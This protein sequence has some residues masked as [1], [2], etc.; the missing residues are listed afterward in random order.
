MISVQNEGQD[1]VVF[2]DLS[3]EYQIMLK[4]RRHEAIDAE[5]LANQ[6]RKD[7]DKRITEIRMNAYNLGW[8]DKAGRKHKRKNFSGYMF[9]PKDGNEFIGY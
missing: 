5:L 3:I 4:Y 2:I 7:L 9:K 6:I 8:S 1:V